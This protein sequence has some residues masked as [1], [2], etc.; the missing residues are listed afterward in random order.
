MVR[1]RVGVTLVLAALAGAA[2]V[3]DRASA[4]F[5]TPPKSLPAL[6][7]T[8]QLAVDGT[9][10]EPWGFTMLCRRSP[11][12]CTD[13]AGRLVADGGGAVRLDHATLALVERA[14]RLVNQAI[15]PQAE[16]AGAPDNWKVGGRS[17]DCEDYALAKREMLIRLGLPS[18]ALRMAT[19]HLRSGE[20]HAVLVV[21]TDRGDLV[22]DNLSRRV[23]TWDRSGI[24]FDTIQNGHDARVWERVNLAGTA[25][26]P[27][28]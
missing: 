11:E 24:R 18:S 1:K 10:H 17:G 5:V 4:G 13:R 8:T 16:K 23:R 6:P 3:V 21:R 28:S 14:H 19:G 25:A 15:R 2:F 20:Y 7:L 9:A 27:T 12:I 22:L 26:P